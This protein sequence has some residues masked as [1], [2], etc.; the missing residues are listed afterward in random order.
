[1]RECHNKQ[2]PEEKGGG[3]MKYTAK[4]FNGG[5]VL[6]VLETDSKKEVQ[7]MFNRYGEI[8]SIRIWLNGRKLPYC[9]SNRLFL[10]RLIQHPD[11]DRL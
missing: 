3:G 4:A 11:F 6:E 9:E 5:R 2:P 1:M 7:K 8:A 10:N